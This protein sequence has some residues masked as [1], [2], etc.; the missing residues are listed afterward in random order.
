MW[1]SNP[2]HRPPVF[3]AKSV[4][5]SITLILPMKVVQTIVY[6]VATRVRQNG[7]EVTEGEWAERC[8]LLRNLCLVSRAFRACTMPSLYERIRLVHLGSSSLPKLMAT[9]NASKIRNDPLSSI[10]LDGYGN[11]VRS[12]SL[13]TKI[14]KDGN[15]VHAISQAESRHIFRMMPHLRHVSIRD[16]VFATRQFSNSLSGNILDI[17]AV[18]GLSMLNEGRFLEGYSSL[19]ILYIAGT[20]STLPSAQQPSLYRAFFPSLHT[21]TLVDKYMLGD[22]LIPRVLEQISLCVMPQLRHFHCVSQEL[23]EAIKT[24]FLAFI[25]ERG[26]LLHTLVIRQASF[27]LHDNGPFLSAVLA[28]C[29]NLWQVA[30]SYDSFD[31]P[32]II[33]HHAKLETLC[34]D[35][36]GKFE[37]EVE[38][39]ITLGRQFRESN[40]QALPNLKAMQVVSHIMGTS[41]SVS[42]HLSFLARAS[43]VMGAQTD[44]LVIQ[45]LGSTLRTGGSAQQ[46]NSTFQPW[47]RNIFRERFLSGPVHG[48]EKGQSQMVELLMGPEWTYY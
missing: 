10:A 21:I 36:G 27:Y 8:T 5:E 28:I 32:H 35:V 45:S 42:L 33:P 4:L 29:P 31:T 23:T 17:Q 15:S 22:D 38:E 43:I 16:G 2:A 7:Y 19:Q 11:Y 24:S 9:L 48:D 47:F 12:L 46:V 30:V 25:R 40:M 37:H 18:N 26:H 34:F 44:I 6:F 20:L 1:G 13:V 14:D 39:L 3:I 41:V